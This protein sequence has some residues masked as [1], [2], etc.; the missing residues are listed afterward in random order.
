MVYNS[1]ETRYAATLNK[2]DNE[3][4][5]IWRSVTGLSIPQRT[6]LRHY[7]SV[8]AVMCP[9]RLTA[10]YILLTWKCTYEVCLQ[11][12]PSRCRWPWHCASILL[13]F[14]LTQFGHSLG[15]NNTN[16]KFRLLKVKSPEHFVIA[17]DFRM[18]T[19]WLKK[20]TEVTGLKKCV[21]PPPQCYL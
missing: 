6:A 10:K 16:R 2:G 1:V 17:T 13:P 3:T 9:T 12:L 15:T 11:Q 18:K 19:N 4:C 21:P 7:R 5:T 8:G 20:N 14:S